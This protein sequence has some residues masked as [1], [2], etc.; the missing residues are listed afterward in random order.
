MKRPNTKRHIFHGRLDLL[1]NIFVIVCCAISIFPIYWLFTGAIKYSS[2]ITKIPPDWWPHRVTLKNFRKIF[3]MYPVLN[4]LL[5]SFVITLVTVFLVVVVSSMAAFA[6]SKMIFF[7]R[8]ALI[9][10]IMAC[11]LIPIEIYI[12]PLY[13]EI[14]DMGLQ[15]KYAGYILPCVAMPFGVY[16][17][18]N[19]YDEIP[20]EIIDA[21]AIDG[22]GKVKFFYYCGIPLSKPGI[23]ALTILSFVQIWN[24]YLWQLLMSTSDEKSY[25]VI[26]GLARV[27]N[28][29]GKGTAD[30]AIFDYGLRYA[31]ATFTAVPILIIFLI[32]Q[33]YFTEGIS[34]GAVK[35]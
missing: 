21:A 9:N 34:A 1:L 30:S 8:K 20:D 17:L 7:G 2:D 15:G 27:I 24:N 12:L 6:L 4:W 28:S 25:T 23:G 16:L 33:R 18:K 32:F 31:T 10:V 5:N 11:L 14:Y 29:T 26:V 13:S 19:F 22:C 3:D 35:G